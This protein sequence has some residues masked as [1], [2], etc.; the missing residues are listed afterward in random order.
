MVADLERYSKRGSALQRAAQAQFLEALSH[1]AVTAGLD[2]GSWR[3]QATG[4]GEVAVLPADVDEPALRGA[5][6]QALD[7]HLRAHN[8]TLLPEAKLRVRVS[9]HEGPVYLDAANGF[10]GTAVNEAARLVDAPPLKAAL[11]ALQAAAVACIVSE[12]LYRDVVRERHD[13]VR[14]E[15]FR[16]IRVTLPEKDFDEPAWIQVV[17][18]DVTTVDLQSTASSERHLAVPTDDP[19]SGI[20]TGHVK[21]GHR[22]QVAIGPG[23]TAIG[24]MTDNNR[25]GR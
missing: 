9:F 4:D 19:T 7:R 11:Q 8:A 5:F 16:E 14:P 2:R 18:E 12:G 6:L 20:R 3:R 25:T 22:S 13:G 1:A 10:A 21:A 15:R 17:D 23:A 24:R